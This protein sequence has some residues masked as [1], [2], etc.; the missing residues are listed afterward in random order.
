MKYAILALLLMYFL[1][2]GGCTH[3]T[4]T[5]ARS[6][7]SIQTTNDQV[8]ADDSIIIRITPTATPNKEV[9]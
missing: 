2:S 1:I 8:P 9:K 6:E 5:P 3:T 7:S 4:I